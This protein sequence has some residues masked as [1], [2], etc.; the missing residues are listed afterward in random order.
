[1][2]EIALMQEQ[3]ARLRYGDLRELPQIFGRIYYH[4]YTNSN[5]SRP[6]TILEDLS[7]VL[8]AKLAAEV[9]G[10]TNE[11]REF[12]AGKGSADDCLA[13]LLASAYPDLVSG[14]LTFHLNDAALRDALTDLTEVELSDAPA[15]ALGEAFQ[16]LIGPRVRGEKG[17][18][19][20]PRSLVNAMIEVLEPKPT[21][22]FL[23]PACGTGGFLAE[24]AM[25]HS[26]NGGTDEKAG[27]MVGVDKDAGLSRFGA[28]LLRILTNGSATICNFNSLDCEKWGDSS[29]SVPRLGEYDCVATNPPFGARIGLKEPRILR[30]YDF[31]YEW[32]ADGDS[33]SMIRTGVLRSTQDPQILF[34]ELCVRALRPGGRLGIVLPEGLFGNTN[35][36]YIWDWLEKRGE[37]F[38]LLD[39]PRTT[40]QPGTDTK[41]N[42]L[43]FRKGPEAELNITDRQDA[44]PTR[45]S[46]ALA[47]GHDRR[48]RTTTSSGEPYPDDFREIG[49]A[50]NNTSA[51]LEWWRVADLRGLRY[52]V[53]R[54]FWEDHALSA[55]EE[56]VTN[57][58]TRATLQ[59]LINGGELT[60]RKGHE[61]GSEAYGTG[62]I[63]FVRTSD[64][65]NY[66]INADPTK[67]VSKAVYDRFASQQQLAPGDILVVADGRYRI[68]QTAMVTENNMRCV[69]QSHLKILSLTSTARITP[70]E[71]LFALTLPHVKLRIRDL[72]FVQSTLGTLGKRL[73]ELNVPLLCGKG[74]WRS[75][76]D[77]FR[78]TLQERDRLLADLRSM[79]PPDITL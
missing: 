42:V 12:V 5:A 65:I 25:W 68:G 18:F 40:F 47:C 78:A 41:T 74:P 54:Y 22:N 55:W 3:S 44:N 79:E 48:G 46:V 10:S 75:Y 61:V 67:A 4:L 35:S 20:T 64:V 1:M 36:R 6:E 23:D 70:Y 9:N 11:L 51:K 26:I 15:H 33:K 63:P 30:D 60:V 21:G 59:E 77:N 17:Q 27:A 62:D 53:P 76:V 24:A 73:F 71:L 56:S 45:I 16:A 31:G 72:V 39:C 8:L 32:N 7:L 43:F 28:A 69:V 50:Y 57:G 34:V 38:A 49:P 52:L 19:F 58:A 13:P 66:E 29:I 14:K 37:I 2:R